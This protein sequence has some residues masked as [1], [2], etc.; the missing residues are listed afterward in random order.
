MLNI[1]RITGGR[2]GLRAGRGAG[3][4]SFRRRPFRSWE[5]ETL[6]AR[7]LL[8]TFI[9]DRTGDV[10]AGSGFVGDLRYA[11]DRADQDTG[12]STILIVPRLAGQTITL[13]GGPLE[14]T[15]RSGTLTIA[16]SP[17]TVSGGGRSEVFALSP[18]ATAT[19]RGLTITAG[20]GSRGGAIYNDG[21]LTLTDDTVSGNSAFGGGGGGI[22]NDVYGTLTISRSTVSG[23]T[24]FLGY[25]GGVANAG[26]MTMTDSTVSGN[27]SDSA[28][29]GGVANAGTMTIGNSTVSGN[30]A[31]TGG[32]GISNTS[33]LTITDA[34]ISRNSADASGGGIDSEAFVG[35]MV[36]L[37][38]TIVAGDTS[39]GD[40]RTDDVI[41]DADLDNS[42][43][44]GGYDLVGS[45]DLGSLTH[46]LVGVAP[47]LGALQDNGGPTWT[48]ALLPGS[49]A[50]RAGNP[51]LVPAGTITD[52]RGFPYAR[53]VRGRVDIGAFE[54]QSPRRAFPIPRV[55][56]A[57]AVG[58]SKVIVGL[59]IVPA[60]HP[61]GAAPSPV[62]TPMA[63]ANRSLGGD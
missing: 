13:T 1:D 33:A 43:L 20:V 49:P 56:L 31:V 28:N 37:D 9:V 11:I 61:H 30:S 50:I 63:Q 47:R 60:R 41:D 36:T 10:G 53:I 3:A 42:H 2:F 51:E 22:F 38:N 39:T 35:G 23:N 18:T 55:R 8:S 29:G 48:Q 32:G 24:S 58:S 46:T 19:I 25:G 14:I 26:T 7:A 34:T 15:K 57:P 54:V 52:Q 59:T 5:V 16:G 44:V 27:T 21:K 12:D 45:G 6:E 17:L 4:R 62:G 40:P